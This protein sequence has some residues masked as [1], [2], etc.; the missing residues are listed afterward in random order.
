MARAPRLALAGELHLLLQ[1]GHNRQRVFVD[2]RDREAYLA[3]LREVAVQYGVAIHA[4]ALLDADVHL[5]AT[6]SA[7]GSLSRLMQSLGRRY[8]AAFNR[9][10]GRSGTL[11]A[12]RFRAGLIDGAALGADALVY[13]ETLPVTAGLVSAA[14]D[15]TWSSATHHLGRRR[16][17]LIA[18]HPA[19]WTL[20]NTPFERELAHAHNL[21][22]GV[23][24]ALADRFERAAMQGRPVGSAAFGARIAQ[25]TGASMH[26]KPRGRPAR[27]STQGPSDYV[28]T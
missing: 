21:R 25:Q 22:D 8:V 12:G 28:P 11:W 2:E 9:R 19:Y 10:H 17:F 24:V 26:A 3:M 20:G 23:S 6:P 4:Y 15:W 14:G 1:R 18:E 13:V 27:K 5:L 7:A 16:D